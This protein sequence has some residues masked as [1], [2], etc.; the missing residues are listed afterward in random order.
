MV[1]TGRRPDRPERRGDLTSL[2][3]RALVAATLATLMTGAI[4]GIFEHGQRG[5]LGL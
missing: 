3:P 1:R 5:L 2:G 4:A